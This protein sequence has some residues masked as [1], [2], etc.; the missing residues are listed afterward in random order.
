MEK[1]INYIICRLPSAGDP[2][3]ETCGWSKRVKIF[4]EDISVNAR[5]EM[6]EGFSG[7]ADKNGLLE[8]LGG[9]NKKPSKVFIVHGEE[10]S[11]IEFSSEIKISLT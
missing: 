9:F 3:K 7:H 10:E 2:W 6:L 1:G 5:I 8:W 4:G 11:M